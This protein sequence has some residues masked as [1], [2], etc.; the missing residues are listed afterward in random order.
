MR[1][2]SCD[3]VI[4]GDIETC[5]ECGFQANRQAFGC[6]RC[7]GV[8]EPLGEHYFHLQKC[9]FRLQG[10]PQIYRETLPVEIFQCN[11]CRRLEFYAM[12][13]TGIHDK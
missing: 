11:T 9:S 6:A 8:M 7:A 2:P 4:S 13:P 5:P 1:C 10:V 3:Q 12:S